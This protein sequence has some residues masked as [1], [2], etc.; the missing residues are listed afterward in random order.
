MGGPARR[1]VRGGGADSAIKE[2]RTMRMVAK[3][4]GVDAGEGSK[5]SP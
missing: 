4:A 3:T 2:M 5:A 1:A